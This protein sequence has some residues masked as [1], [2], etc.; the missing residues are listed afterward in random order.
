M[1]GTAFLD[2][3]E[4]FDR[5]NHNL[6]PKLIKRTTPVCIVRL[7]LSWYRRQTMQVKWGIN[8]SSPFTVT[9]GGKARGSYEPILIFSLPWWI[10]R[11]AGFSQSRMHYGKYGC[12]SVVEFNV[13]WIFV[14]TV[15][16]F[17]KSPLI[18]TKQLVFFFAQTS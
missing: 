8:F 4:A 10:L 6:F 14:V 11:T 13:F 17:T 3:S 7:L 9:S 12:E 18:V 2:A 1:Q 16:L 15:L 5:T